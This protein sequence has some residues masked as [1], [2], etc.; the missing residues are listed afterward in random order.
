MKKMI[1]LS[2]VFC[3]IILTNLKADNTWESIYTV[4]PSITNCTAGA[5]TATE[6]SK[7]L[8]KINQIRKIHKLSLLSWEDLGD[9][10]AN[11]AT[12]ICAS[13]GIL[14]HQPASTYACYTQAGYNGA[15][16]S[17]LHL[18]FSSIEYLGDSEDA[19][20]GWL[21]DDMSASGDELGHRRAI[22][23]PFLEKVSVGRT[24]GFPKTGDYTSYFATSMSMKYQDY[25]VSNS[26]NVTVDYVACP[27]QN[28]PIAFFNKAFYL[29]FHA[30][31][32]KTDLWSNA[33]VDY[34]SAVVT[35]KTEAQVSVTVSNQKYDNT[36]WGSL[37]NCLQW[38]ATGLQ[39][40]VKYLVTITNVKNNGQSYDYS[41]WFKLTDEV[42]VDALDT[43]E[44]SAPANNSVDLTAPISLSWNSVANATKYNVKIAKD[45]TF[46]DIVKDLTGITLTNTEFNDPEKLTTYYWKVQALNETLNSAW[47]S[48]WS[49]ITKAS[50]VVSVPTLTFPQNGQGDIRPTDNLTWDA[51]SGTDIKYGLQ[52]CDN[53]TFN[54]T[55]VLNQK[56]MVENTYSLSSLNLT[57][58]KMYF[59][60][61]MAYN[62]E[63][64]SDWSAIKHFNTYNPAS[65]DESQNS[66][67]SLAPNPVKDGNINLYLT[68]INTEKLNI[69][70]YSIDGQILLSYEIPI[71]VN[72]NVFPVNISNLYYGTYIMNIS[73]SDKTVNRIFTVMK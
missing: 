49:F 18:G 56:N 47:S 67:L 41:Y 24:D 17:N 53:N 65:I 45:A 52:V 14:D 43:P 21:I 8:S 7:I 66:N 63:N 39:D 25:V 60:R 50:D 16:T 26:P 30:I 40:G 6:K 58:N 9:N 20:I 64:S 31:P 51:V 12:L 5:L 4:Q 42:I 48:V 10:E 61:V 23:N 15:N 38:K 29:S 70:I 32:D 54:G 35:M 19:I 34:S 2:I 33:S 73:Y 72:S 28:Y 44:L 55:F 1:Y 22:I 11:Q 62:S 37:P 69:R 46:T 59:W 3:A 71:N 27:Y 13:N 68:N 57:T 36:G